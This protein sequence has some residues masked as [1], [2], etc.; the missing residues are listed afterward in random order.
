MYTASALVP[1]SL[2][3]FRY[4]RKSHVHDRS[5]SVNGTAVIFKRLQLL[6]ICFISGNTTTDS[7]WLVVDG[8][9]SSLALAIMCP[10]TRSTR[11]RARD[12]VLIQVSFEFRKRC[13][14]VLVQTVRDWY[15]I[16]ISELLNSIWT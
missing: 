12:R 2:L 14:Y 16:C 9:R 1:T 15:E 5:S 3:I 10:M 6:Q 4:C 8:Q 13:Q 11:S 7:Q